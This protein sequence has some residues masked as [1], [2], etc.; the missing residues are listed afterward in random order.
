MS[1]FTAVQLVAGI[2][3]AIGVI[4]CDDEGNKIMCAVFA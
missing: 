2:L 1:L 4:V 3:C